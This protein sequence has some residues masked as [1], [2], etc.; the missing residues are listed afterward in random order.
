M[1]G[2]NIVMITFS[3]WSQEHAR[4]CALT[5][6]CNHHL[7]KPVSVETIESSLRPSQSVDASNRAVG[8]YRKIIG[9]AGGDDESFR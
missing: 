3:S 4:E 6:G 8:V 5:A 9:C 7:T 1:G 2:D